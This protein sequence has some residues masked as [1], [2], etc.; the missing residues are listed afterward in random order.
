MSYGPVHDAVHYRTGNRSV[1][2]SKDQQAVS[3]IDSLL[4]EKVESLASILGDINEKI[5]ERHSVS[6]NVSG[7]IDQHYLYVKFKLLEMNH[8]PLNGVKAIELRRS[9]LE[10]QLDTLLNEQRREQV[11]CFQDI[12][13]LKREFWKWFKEY[14]DVAQRM[15]IVRGDV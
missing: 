13:D 5:T 10:K 6:A 8:W 12:A 1:V 15:R 4:M 2:P 9:N 7:L 3:S 14:C 11:L